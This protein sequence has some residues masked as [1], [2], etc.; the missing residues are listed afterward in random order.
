MGNRKCAISFEAREQVALWIEQ[1]SEFPNS[2]EERFS[3]LLFELLRS[4]ASGTLLSS[5]YVNI[6]VERELHS[7]YSFDENGLL[8]YYSCTPM[9]AV[10]L[11]VCPSPD[12]FAAFMS[13]KDSRAA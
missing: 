13:E 4:I 12:F 1:L 6:D 7:I 3:E 5:Q 9:H 2:V 10:L 11:E 8:G